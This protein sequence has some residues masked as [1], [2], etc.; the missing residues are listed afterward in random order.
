MIVGLIVSPGI[1]DERRRHAAGVD[2]RCD[3]IDQLGLECEHLG[4]DRDEDHG[5]AAAGKAPVGAGDLDAW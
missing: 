5:R 2:E 1:G 3:G 4:A